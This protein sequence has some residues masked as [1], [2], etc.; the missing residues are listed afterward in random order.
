MGGAGLAEASR[1]SARSRRNAIQQALADGNTLAR[2]LGG[3]GRCTVEQ[4]AEDLPD[5]G[6]ATMGLT[7]DCRF[8][9]IVITTI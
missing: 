4:G 2:C 5:H 1:V 7:W 8:I 9:S 6:R 3:A